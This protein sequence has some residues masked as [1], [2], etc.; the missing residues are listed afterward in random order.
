MLFI[1]KSQPKKELTYSFIR[2]VLNGTK[3][4]LKCSDIASNHIPRR[5]CNYSVA[6]LYAEWSKHPEFSQYFPTDSTK[7]PSAGYFWTVNMFT[8]FTRFLI[9]F[10]LKL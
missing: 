8:K 3:K 4:L 10:S 2:G 1:S 9:Q 7:I 6:S 5:L